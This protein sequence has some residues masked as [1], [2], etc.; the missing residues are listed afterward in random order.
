[1]TVA[2]VREA[3]RE[4]TSPRQPA[5]PPVTE[6]IPPRFPEPKA[7]SPGNGNWREQLEHV[8]AHLIEHAQIDPDFRIAMGEP[9]MG[10]VSLRRSVT[11]SN[12]FLANCWNDILL[13]RLLKLTLLMGM[14]TLWYWQWPYHGTAT[15]EN[16]NRKCRQLLKS[17]RPSI[18]C[19]QRRWHPHLV[20]P[21][22][23]HL[24]DDLQSQSLRHL[25][26]LNLNQSQCRRGTQTHTSS[27]RTTQ[28]VFKNFP[29]I[30]SHYKWSTSSNCYLIYRSKKELSS[31]TLALMPKQILNSLGRRW[32]AWVLM[33]T[34]SPM[35][36]EQGQLLREWKSSRHSRRCLERYEM[37]QNIN[38]SQIN[39]RLISSESVYP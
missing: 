31:R 25:L 12:E 18:N 32:K 7:C 15:W 28:L 4:L 24:L 23:N 29:N 36:L 20:S 35:S 9:K 39:S 17:P 34:P 19:H 5:P 10:R 14:M 37:L 30:Q 3:V 8:Y 26:H 16:R 6:Y 22:A 38:V 1:M 2:D 27:Q 13:C 21:Q 33:K 11:E